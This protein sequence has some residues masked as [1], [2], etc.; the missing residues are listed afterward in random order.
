MLLHPPYMFPKVDDILTKLQEH[1]KFVEIF[2]HPK[3]MG[4]KC[5]VSIDHTSI[6]PMHACYDLYFT[7]TQDDPFFN[8]PSSLII[9]IKTRDNT[10]VL[11]SVFY[12]KE[13]KTLPT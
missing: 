9:P 1:P 11:I 13:K 3:T 8:L 6:Y 12:E 2:R 7:I 10:H 5:Y 4:M